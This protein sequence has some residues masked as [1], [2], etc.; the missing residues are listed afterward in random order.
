MPFQGLE[1]D[2]KLSPCSLHGQEAL[3][4]S[5]LI[6]MFKKVAQPLLTPNDPTDKSSTSSSSSANSL[7]PSADIFYT[8]TV[9]TVGGLLSCLPFPKKY[10]Y[11]LKNRSIRAPL[12]KIVETASQLKTSP[13]KPVLLAC[14]AT[15]RVIPWECASPRTH[16]LRSPG[17][18]VCLKN[19]HVHVHNSCAALGGLE[20][21]EPGE[22][23][24]IAFFQ[25]SWKMRD[26]FMLAGRSPPRLCTMNYYLQVHIPQFRAR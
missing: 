18:T 20:C 6:E 25:K 1:A 2:K 14:S 3:R 19:A 22:W 7:L 5:Q 9:Q 17:C 12:P 23:G 4:G 26:E 10:T 15:L 11:S 13:Q 8:S 16:L 24:M 21:G